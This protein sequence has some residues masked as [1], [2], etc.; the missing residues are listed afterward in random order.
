MNEKQYRFRRKSSRI[1]RKEGTGG[2][3]IFPL[4]MMLAMLAVAAALYTQVILSELEAAG[5]FVLRSQLEALVQSVVQTAL[6][7][8]KKTEIQKGFWPVGRMMPGNHAVNLSVEVKR[9]DEL[10]MRA[11]FVSAADEGGHDF[12]LRQC[13]I[14]FPDAL[15][16]QFEHSAFVVLKSLSQGVSPKESMPVTSEEEGAVFPQFYVDDFA[17]WFSRDFPGM[18]EL[19]QEGLNNWIY[20]DDGLLEFP[21]GLTVKGRGI[22]AF[23][24]PVTIRDQVT[25]ADRIIIIAND[26]VRIGR[27]VKLQKAFILCRG[28]LTIGDDSIVNGGFLVQ[29]KAILGNNVL[30]TGDKE[31]IKEFQTIIS[32]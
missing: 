5:E 23:T 2:F 1:V 15:V 16:E 30:L 20:I 12:H 9:L 31:V 7:Q 6:A 22:L 21:Q 11:L 18:Q 26:D 3:V 32:Y 19:Q 24:R 28:N 17:D 27:H 13:R 14:A 8:E 29:H 4:L 10:G 25:F